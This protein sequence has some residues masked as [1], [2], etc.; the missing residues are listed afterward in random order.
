MLQTLLKGDTQFV[1]IVKLTDITHVCMFV[2]MN[3]GMYEPTY[4]VWLDTLQSFVKLLLESLKKIMVGMMG[5][6]RST[7][8]NSD[9]CLACV[10]FFNSI[11]RLDPHSF[12]LGTSH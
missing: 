8:T 5:R 11:R 3:A 1:I 4:L 7:D 9:A 12:E 2:C 10:M 6:R